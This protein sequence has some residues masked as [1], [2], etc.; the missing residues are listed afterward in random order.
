[1][2]ASHVGSPAHLEVDPQPSPALDDPDQNLTATSQETLS[3]N[4]P[5]KVLPNT[6]STD[7]M[8]NNE[9]VVVSGSEL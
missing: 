5:V 8:G 4:H 6:R 7:T 3:Q 9:S 2:T 1:M